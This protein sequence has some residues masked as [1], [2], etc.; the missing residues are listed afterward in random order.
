MR[1]VIICLVILA[2]IAGIHIGQEMANGM[3]KKAMELKPAGQI[4]DLEKQSRAA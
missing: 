2:L 3:S 4:I 1:V